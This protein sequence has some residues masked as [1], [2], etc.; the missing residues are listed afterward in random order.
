MYILTINF[1]DTLWWLSI[2]ITKS[3]WGFLTAILNY[4]SHINA[5]MNLLFIFILWYIDNRFDEINKHM[6]CLLMRE[7]YGFQCIIFKWKGENLLLVYIDI[8]Y[9]LTITRQLTKYMSFD[10][11]LHLELCRI[12]RELNSIFGMQITFEMLSYFASIS[13]MCYALFVMLVQKDK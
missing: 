7:E 6:K 4:C 12:A 10:R 9:V 2:P 11:H 1:Y 3:A 8:L 13:T 5:F